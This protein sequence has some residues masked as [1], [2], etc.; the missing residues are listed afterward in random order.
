MNAW[1]LKYHSYDKEAEPVRETLCTLGNGYFATRGT[2]ESTQADDVHYPG[3]YLAGGYNR[4]NSEVSGKLIENED[5]VNWPNWLLLTFKPED[6]EWFHCDK[7]DILDY[8]QTLDLKHGVLH[9]HIHVRDKKDRETILKTRRMVLMQPKNVGMICW[10]IIPQNWSGKVMVKSGLDASVTNAGVKRYGDLNSQHLDVV[11]LGRVKEKGMYVKVQSN[12]SEVTMAQ[13]AT[14]DVYFEQDHNAVDRTTTEEDHVISQ[15]LAFDVETKQS[16]I[17]EKKVSLFTSR[18]PAITNPLFEAQKLL[19]RVDNFEAMEKKQC[20]AWEQIWER[21]D[22]VIDGSEE[23]QLL[24][25]LHIFHLFQTTSANTVDLDVGVPPRGWHGEAYRGHILWDELFIFPFLNFSVPELTRSLL[26]YRYRRLPEARAAAHE[27]G[28]EGAMFP[29]QSGSNGREESQYIHLNPQS[30][31]WIPDDTHL[32]RHVN[33]AIAYNIW[34]YY[35]VTH[36]REFMSFYGAEMLMSI[37]KFW[38]SKVEF[39]EEK[40]R[41]EIRRIVGPDEYHTQYPDADKPGINNNAY[42]NFMAVWTLKNSIECIEKLDSWRQKELMET[43]D[44]DEEQIDRWKHISQ[45]MFIPFI[46]DGKIIN[47]FEGYE[48]LEELKLSQYV[49]KYGENLRLDRILEK[50]GDSVNR[51]K[52]AKQADVL[53]LFYLFSSEELTSLFNWMGYKFNPSYIPENIQYYESRTSHGSTLSKLVHS[54]VTARSNRPKSWKSFREALKSDVEDVQGGTT[55]EGIHLGA[56]AGTVDM[57]QRGYTGLQL[58]N[59]MLWLNPKLP[60]Q[61]KKLRF[62]IKYRGHWLELDISKDQLKISSVGGWPHT[63]PLMIGDKQYK[64]HEGEEKVIELGAK[65]PQKA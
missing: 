28:Y 44:I 25:R 15:Q 24:L 26:M 55:Q 63:V 46:D 6:G 16:A 11:E 14:T 33:A 3:T 12:Q 57:V 41:Y 18:D 23:D 34:L 8:T 9:R 37:S 29:W 32:Q 10:E 45:N 2:C 53:M 60:E 52:I 4:L 61:I 1:K 48:K 54:R 13:A 17:I 7:M 38:A 65:K 22:I 40:E 39:S 31:N 56:M 58:W 27:S 30:G 47:Q 43:L 64:I 21:C 36:D 62:K 19:D 5:L 59:D 50:E 42:T 35:Q 20:Q 49:K 51:Y